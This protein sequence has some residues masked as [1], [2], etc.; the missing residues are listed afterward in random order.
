MGS[1]TTILRYEV[2]LFLGVLALIIFYQLLTGR[3]NMRRL[4]FAKGRAAG[5]P[6]TSQRTSPSTQRRTSGLSPSRIQ[7]L[8]ITI[9]VAI[10]LLA[11]VVRD[12]SQFPEIPTG[13]LLL[14]AGSEAIYLARKANNL[15]LR[16]SFRESIRRNSQA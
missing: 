15:L 13:L 9:G 4:L 1:V 10:Y 6:S 8:V 16:K 3:I 5:G 11:E 7:L 2:I 12:P 14:M